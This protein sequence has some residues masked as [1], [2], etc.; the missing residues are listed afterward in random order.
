MKPA[1]GYETAAALLVQAFAAHNVELRDKLMSIKSSD[2][3]NAATI[4]QPWY[5]AALLMVQGAQDAKQGQ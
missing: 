1:T 3:M 2:A 5:V 4:L